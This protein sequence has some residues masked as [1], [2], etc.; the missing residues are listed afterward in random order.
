MTLL[1]AFRA[2]L[3]ARQVRATL[4][5]AAVALLLTACST[6]NE[7]DRGANQDYVDDDGSGARP[8]LPMPAAP[9]T[10]IPAAKPKPAV[11]AKRR[12][13]QRPLARVAPRPTPKTIERLAA[14]PRR[15]AQYSP[16]VERTATGVRTTQDY[17]AQYRTKQQRDNAATVKAYRADK[18]TRM[19]R[20]YNNNN[21]LTR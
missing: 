21:L 9:P 15:Q 11:V 19:A 5:S 7:T 20:A 4:L 18:N 12:P 8:T 6:A 16:M 10:I 2:Y 17:S 14:Q 3:P 1:S 13:T